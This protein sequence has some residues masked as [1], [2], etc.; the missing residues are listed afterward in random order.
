M[1]I[2]P[3]MNQWEI[4]CSTGIGSRCILRL[5]LLLLV[6]GSELLKQ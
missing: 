5:C 1:S 2:A 6:L 3:E 4:C